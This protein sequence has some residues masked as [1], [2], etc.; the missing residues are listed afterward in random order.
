MKKLSQ[1]EGRFEW[2]NVKVTATNNKLMDSTSWHKMILL[3]HQ[4][5]E[6]YALKIFANEKY[7]KRW[8]LNSF[9]FNWQPF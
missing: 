2:L 9:S 5:Y 8:E 4:E 3:E 6:K 1:I 7:L